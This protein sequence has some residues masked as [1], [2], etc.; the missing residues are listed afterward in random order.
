MACGARSAGEM[1]SGKMRR[2]QEIPYSLLTISPSN[3][4]TNTNRLAGSRPEDRRERGC[5]LGSRAYVNGPPFGT[6][7]RRFWAR[8]ALRDPPLPRR[9]T[10]QDR[11]GTPY[12]PVRPSQ[13][14]TLLRHA[15]R[16]SD[17]RASWS[18]D[19]PLARLPG[20]GP[21]HV[22]NGSIHVPSRPETRALCAHPAIPGIA[23]GRVNTRPDRGLCA[24]CA[25]GS[26]L[27]ATVTRGQPPLIAGVPR[28]AASH[29]AD[30]HVPGTDSPRRVAPPLPWP[31]SCRT[32]WDG[33]VP[34]RAVR[35][36]PP[37]P[38]PFAQ[39]WDCAQ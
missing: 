29:C 3:H 30:C 38:A 27:Q 14:T 39:P 22:K 7:V 12:S 24:G 4:L 15:R 21:G 32:A 28:N 37:A 5:L 18:L 31:G 17:A 26:S 16:R 8:S 6:R 20:A 23:R 19:H 33:N 25:G 10:R 13:R 36:R 11:R 34:R 9:S 2:P 35:S 1:V